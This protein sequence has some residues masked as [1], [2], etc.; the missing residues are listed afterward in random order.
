[1][2]DQESRLVLFIADDA[3]SGLIYPTRRGIIAGLGALVAAPAVVRAA[4]LITAGSQVAQRGTAT[5]APISNLQARVTVL[6]TALTPTGVRWFSERAIFNK[7][8]PADAP[9]HPRSDYFMSLQRQ[10]KPHGVKFQLN[11]GLWTPTVFYAQPTDPRQTV[12][13]NDPARWTLDNVSVPAG[14]T[15]SPDSDGQLV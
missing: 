2:P 4:S 12:V 11:L 3:M 9:R 13:Q 10:I 6:E 15:G 1:M 7:P 5:E 8:V 14:T